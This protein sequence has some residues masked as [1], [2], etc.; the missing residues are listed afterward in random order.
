MQREIESLLAAYLADRDREARLVQELLTAL[1]VGSAARQRMLHD[2]AAAVGAAPAMEPADAPVIR[3][4]PAFAG[5]DIT[6]AIARLREA[7]DATTH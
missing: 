1:A 5:S 7:R 3:D 6:A 2:I 4:M